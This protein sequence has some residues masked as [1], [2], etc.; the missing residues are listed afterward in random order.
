M[1]YGAQMGGV[2]GRPVRKHRVYAGPR[3]VRGISPPSPR[4]VVECGGGCALV[5]YLSLG[6]ELLGRV[7]RLSSRVHPKVT[8]HVGFFSSCEDAS[9]WRACLGA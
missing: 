8:L 3:T 5:A 2:R 7:A 1:V 9:S 4:L 6:L